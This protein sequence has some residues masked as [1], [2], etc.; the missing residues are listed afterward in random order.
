MKKPAFWAQTILFN[1]PE[2]VMTA[3]VL[4]KLFALF[5]PM[6]NTFS[7]GD[8][9]GAGAPKIGTSYCDPKYWEDYG[10][11]SGED[12]PFL[13]LGPGYS[14]FSKFP[15]FLG[16]LFSNH[17]WMATLYGLLAFIIP[18]WIMGFTKIDGTAKRKTGW[19]KFIDNI[20]VADY[21]KV[22]PNNWEHPQ[23]K[24]F[25]LDSKKGWGNF[26]Q[27]SVV[28]YVEENELTGKRI[29]DI[30]KA[31]ERINHFL[32]HE[33]LQENK[34]RY[35]EKLPGSLEFAFHDGK[36]NEL[37][38]RASM[39]TRNEKTRS[40][41]KTMNT[42][43]RWMNQHD[44]NISYVKNLVDEMPFY[45]EDENTVGAEEKPYVSDEILE[46]WRNFREAIEKAYDEKLSKKTY[47]WDDN[48]A[49]LRQNLNYPYPERDMPF[50]HFCKAYNDH[51][52][53]K[54][55][56]EFE[57]NEDDNII[58]MGDEFIKLKEEVKNLKATIE[59]NAPQNQHENENL[60][61]FE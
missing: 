10:E 53:S 15:Q 61:N 6:S 9:R 51:L 43:N 19:F 4:Y 21:E 25:M 32:L 46:D 16:L 17:M 1:L 59:R 13:H 38:K 18:F 47:A 42:T 39:T 49:V 55:K 12:F 57:E 37:I 48:T 34:A 60:I 8:C 24:S 20:W 40:R 14:V 41:L 30:V 36:L 50:Q 26:H 7:P 33:H 22:E 3:F 11:I 27:S 54:E 45:N 35:T 58:N 28:K 52:N 23:I 31:E 29:A 44:S 5:L 2:F 56:K